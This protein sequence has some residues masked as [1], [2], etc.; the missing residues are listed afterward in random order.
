MRISF[1]IQD[2][3]LK[4]KMKKTT[5]DKRDVIWKMETEFKNEFKFIY[6]NNLKSNLFKQEK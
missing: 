6:G 1:I 2:K 3:H 4:I 5:S